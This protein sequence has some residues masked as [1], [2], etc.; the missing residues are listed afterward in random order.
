MV[1]FPFGHLN[2]RLSGLIG[3]LSKKTESLMSGPSQF[4]TGRL[5]VADLM[6]S[7]PAVVTVGTSLADVAQMFEHSRFRYLLVQDEKRSVVGVVS[8]GDLLSFMAGALS[9]NSDVWKSRPVE[10]LMATRF[11]A[12]SPHADAA[13]VARIVAGSEINCVPVVED[14]Q[15]IGMITPNDLLISWSRL[16]L[17][18]EAAT[19]D[20]V[21]D[22]TNRATFNRR[23]REEWERSCRTKDAIALILFDLDFFKQVNDECGHQTG[24]SVLSMIGSCLRRQLRTYDVVSRI[25]GDEFAALCC[26]FDPKFSDSPIRRLQA[27]VRRLTVP[28]KLKRRQLSLSIGAAVVTS[29]FQALDVNQLFEVADACLYQSKDAGR[30]CAHRVMIGDGLDGIPVCVDELQSVESP[31]VSRD[32]DEDEADSPEVVDFRTNDLQRLSA[33]S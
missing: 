4:H 26:N 28:R 5:K 27:A 17:L 11:I 7:S 1:E 12:S 2:L 32:Y 9:D 14:N 15:L 8:Y 21:T 23:L 30:D 18:I 16:E 6:S 31:R 29:G 24:D 33:T 10:S 20:E 25:G 13:D 22:L 19:T 3:L